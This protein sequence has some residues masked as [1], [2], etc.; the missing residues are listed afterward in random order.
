MGSEGCVGSFRP[1]PTSPLLLEVTVKK[2]VVW[3]L[4]ALLVAGIVVPLGLVGYLEFL[5]ETP[6][7]PRQEKAA[8]G[9]KV[10]AMLSCGGLFWLCLLIFGDEL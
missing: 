5:K 1:A 7:T 8:G 9:A 4:L 2:A 10:L 6:L 3:L